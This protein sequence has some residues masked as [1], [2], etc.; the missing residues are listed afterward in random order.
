MNNNNNNDAISN[1]Y[2]THLFSWDFMSKLDQKDGNAAVKRVRTSKCPC[3][4]YT[5]RIVSK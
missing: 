5:I 4:F 2:K 3:G 1:K